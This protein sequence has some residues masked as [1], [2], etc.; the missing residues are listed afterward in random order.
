MA[1]QIAHAVDDKKRR[2]P[3]DPEP[4]IKRTDERAS[5]GSGEEKKPAD[6]QPGDVEEDTAR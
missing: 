4:G 2:K 3:G 1:M 5:P 6:I